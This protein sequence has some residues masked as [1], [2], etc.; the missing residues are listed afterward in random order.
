VDELLLGSSPQ[1]RHEVLIKRPIASGMARTLPVF[2]GLA[3]AVSLALAGCSGCS[4]SGSNGIGIWSQVGAPSGSMPTGRAAHSAVY[5]PKAERMIVFGGAES[6]TA[7][8][9]SGASNE[10]WAYDPESGQ[11]TNL[12]PSG[13]VPS[14]RI[15][16][17]MAYDTHF[18]KTVMFGGVDV[19]DG[20]AAKLLQDTWAYDSSTNSWA[21]LDPTGSIPPSQGGQCLVYDPSVKR[22]FLFT[23]GLDESTGDSRSEVWSYDLAANQWSRLETPGAVPPARINQ[24]T[25][26]DSRRA[27]ILMFGG[28]ATPPLAFTTPFLHDLWAFDPGKAAWTELEPGGQRAPASYSP[29]AWYD[30][31]RDRMIVFAGWFWGEEGAC[32]TWE[33]DPN[34]NTWV[35]LGPSVSPPAPRIGE[36]VVFDPASGAAILFGGAGGANPTGGDEGLPVLSVLYSDVWSF[37]P[38]ISSG[39]RRPSE[40][41]P[42]AAVVGSEDRR[43]SSSS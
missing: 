19:V 3:L 35:D 41:A 8:R 31:S 15:D 9:L 12:N 18:G 30:S 42:G 11:W 13:A 7:G 26:Y 29:A 37:G 36:S 23:F 2:A 20:E 5:D 22:M 28:S 43:R 40:G 34:E 39:N 33:Y 1:I 4:H 32:E 24:T 14:P 10:T 17:A 21:N 25:V 27:R 6:V 16:H 38:P